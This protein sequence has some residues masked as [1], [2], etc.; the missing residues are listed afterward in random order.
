MDLQVSERW[1]ID[2][3][4]AED[5][6]EHIRSLVRQLVIRKILAP[7]KEHQQP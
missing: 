2:E 7:K 6:V 3:A 5:A 4:R 1:V